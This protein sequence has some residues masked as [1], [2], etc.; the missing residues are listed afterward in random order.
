MGFIVP[1]PIEFQVITFLLNQNLTLRLYGNNI[2]PTNSST[3]GQFTEISGGGYTSKPIIFANWTIT[4]DEP[5]EA[6]YSVQTWTFTGSIDAPGTIYGYY[7]TKNSD[8]SL[9]LAQRFPDILVPFS[10][11]A[12]GGSIIK[13]LPRYT[14]ESQF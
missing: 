12:E 14:V 2:T 6:V 13:V 9:F 3:T 4:Q 8:N 5:T 11:V 10:P 1:D 7:I